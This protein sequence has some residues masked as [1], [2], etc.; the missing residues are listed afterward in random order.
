MNYRCITCTSLLKRITTKDQLFHGT[1]S[2]DPYQNCEFRCPYC[3]SSHEKNVYVKIN[4]PDIL[5][6]ELTNVEE[7]NI[8]IGSVN[9]PYQK[10]EK[11][12]Q[13]TRRLLETIKRYELP[14]HILTKSP[15]VLRDVDLLSTMRSRVTISILSLNPKVN[16]VFEPS[17]P[18]PIHRLQ[19]IQTLRKYGIQTGIALIPVLP[20]LTDNELEKMIKEAK[21]RNA[22]YLIHKYLP[23]NSDYLYKN[24]IVILLYLTPQIN[25]YTGNPFHVPLNSS[26]G[27]LS[28]APS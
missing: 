11:R 16:H 5:A 22:Q 9:D 13:V 23:V 26:I 27:I 1:Y 6:K 19:T 3:D 21:K 17:I 15:L 18:L 7:G 24:E 25:P 20:H 12:Y 28:P 10:A 8:I 4:A 2:I 14:C